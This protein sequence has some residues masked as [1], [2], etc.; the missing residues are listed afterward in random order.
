M[1]RTEIEIIGGEGEVTTA[2]PDPIRVGAGTA[3]FVGGTMPPAAA[4][5]ARIRAAGIEFAIDADSMPDERRYD[6][7]ELWWTMVTIPAGG[8]DDPPGPDPLADGS[9]ARIAIC[10][11]TW[12][13]DPDRLRVQLDSIRE[14]TRDDWVCVI[15]DDC[16]SAESFAALEREVGDDDRFHVS[17]SA[18]RLGF[19]RNFERAIGLAPASAELIALADQ[20]DRWDPDK[21]DVLLAALDREPGA[22][23]AYSDVRIAAADGR[24]LSDTYFFER[25]NNAES[26]ASM[27]ITNNVTGAASMFRRE[28]LATALPFPPGGTGQELYHDH[29]L[30]LCALAQGPLAYVDRP[31]HDYT[32]HDDSVTVAEAEGHWVAPPRGR[33]G[34]VLMRLR[35]YARRLRLASRSPGW[36]SAYVGRYLLIRQLGT[37]LL[38]RLGRER[39]DPRHRRDL[40]RMLAAETSPRA[41]IWLLARSFRPWIGRNDTLARERVVFGGIIWRKLV[42]RR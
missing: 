21:L 40:D 28:L 17:R 35:R 19:L 24:V 7:G 30:A 38:M 18:E 16:S 41:A 2:P 11:A 20:D 37:I 4:A 15:S 6:R 34:A 22:L 32:R 27:L 12:E 1:N 8:D 25:R 33:L 23:L 42:G 36:R 31:T 3:F 14:Q 5:A 10:M 13:P 26:M 9:G 39:I 29:W